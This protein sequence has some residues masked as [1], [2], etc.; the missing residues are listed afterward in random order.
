MMT[1]LKE[2][3]VLMVGKIRTVHLLTHPYTIISEC[4]WR[5]YWEAWIVSLRGGTFLEALWRGSEHP[6][7]MPEKEKE[8]D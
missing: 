3:S 5:V 2:K 4:G 7:P 6:P 8:N 1:G